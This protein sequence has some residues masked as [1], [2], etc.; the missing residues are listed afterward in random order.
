VK[1]D[2]STTGSNGSN[3]KHTNGPDLDLG[4]GP[5]LGLVL[6]QPYWNPLKPPVPPVNVSLKPS[7]SSPGSCPL[8]PFSLQS[9][10]AFEP[11]GS[12]KDR[13]LVRGAVDLWLAV[14]AIQHKTAGKGAAGTV[15][16]TQI[17]AWALQRGFETISG[18]DDAAAIVVMREELISDLDRPDLI[19]RP[20]DYRPFSNPTRRQLRHISED[21]QDAIGTWAYKQGLPSST[22]GAVALMS[23]LVLGPIGK[24][25]KA[26]ISE[27]LDYWS[28]Y[29]SF[30][31]F[32]YDRRITR[33][34]SSGTL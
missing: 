12:R 6:F 18:L 33:V 29:L 7:D 32:Q 24:G 13:F 14:E 17:A 19:P 1:H 25:L 11:K 21:L 4:L 15:S 30:R 2:H 8:T 26:K 3:G 31:R 22:A 10:L 34:K 27:E 5:D 28:E 9:L 16:T 20:W 23:G